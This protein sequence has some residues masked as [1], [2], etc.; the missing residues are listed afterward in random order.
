M[1]VSVF[2]STFNFDVLTGD[3]NQQMTG[4]NE[5]STPGSV[6]LYKER[7]GCPYLCQ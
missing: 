7:T 1:K 2:F 4:S 6:L 5:S 3:L